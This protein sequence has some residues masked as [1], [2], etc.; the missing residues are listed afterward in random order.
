MPRL[1]SGG[2][3]STGKD[4]YPHFLRICQHFLAENNVISVANHSEYRSLPLCGCATTLRDNHHRGAIGAVSTI[5]AVT[6]AW[7][8]LEPMLAMVAIGFHSFR[9]GSLFS[10]EGTEFL[11][12]EDFFPWIILAF[13]AAM[14]VGNVLALVRPPTDDLADS[15]A[16]T[17][18]PLTRTVVMICFGLAAAVWALA[19]LLN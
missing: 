7:C 3:E 14:V 19:S 18:P 17:R 10:Q 8:R 5:Q 16:R 13:G 11:L 9:G 6:T 1:C 2:G 12:G 15:E 4:H